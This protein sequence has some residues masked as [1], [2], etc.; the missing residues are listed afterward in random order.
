MI[1]EVFLKLGASGFTSPGVLVEPPD[2]SGSLFVA[3]QTGA[4]SI[5]RSNGQKELFLDLKPKII[6]L[7]SSYH[8]RRLLGLRFHPK[9]NENGRLFVYYSAPLRSGLS[10]N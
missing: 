9:F 10:K 2:N 4:I 1:P 5:L 7:D 6:R 8:E 3:D